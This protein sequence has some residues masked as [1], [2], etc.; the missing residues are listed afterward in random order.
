MKRTAFVLSAMLLAT[1]SVADSASVETNPAMTLAAID[2]GHQV[3]TPVIPA[4]RTAQPNPVA[5]DKT[6]ELTKSV[7]SQLEQ[8]LAE[9]MN[10]EFDLDF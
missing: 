2:M 5:M 3:R 9:K 8:R 4:A 10:I 6:L 7:N 1:Y